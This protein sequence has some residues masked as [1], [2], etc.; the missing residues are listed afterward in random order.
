MIIRTADHL[1]VQ[2]AEAALASVRHRQGMNGFVAKSNTLRGRE[3]AGRH[4]PGVGPRL[5]LHH[6]AAAG[7][8]SGRDRERSS[9]DV[10]EEFTDLSRNSRTLRHRGRLRLVLDKATQMSD[11]L[12]YPAERPTQARSS[13]P[14]SDQSSAA[15][16]RCRP[17]THAQAG[18]EGRAPARRLGPAGDGG[19][20]PGSCR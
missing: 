7:I 6:P 17:S 13:Y 16:R 5:R 9:T 12:A 4:H 19:P 15:G 11:V 3:P 8:A 10:T 18:G 1:I 2:D 14:G 20:G